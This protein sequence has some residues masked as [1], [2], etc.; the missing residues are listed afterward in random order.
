MLC[1]DPE[2]R[3]HIKNVLLRDRHVLCI[4]NDG[5]RYYPGFIE[6]DEKLDYRSWRKQHIKE[7]QEQGMLD[8][9][10]HE[11]VLENYDLSGAEE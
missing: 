7:M 5:K 6:M 2:E 8:K 10:H 4:E 3:E 1:N 11:T 9:K